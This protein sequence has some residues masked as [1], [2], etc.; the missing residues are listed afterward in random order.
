MLGQITNLQDRVKSLAQ[1]FG[2][3]PD[4]VGILQQVKEPLLLYGLYCRVGY[5][6]LRRNGHYSEVTFN[7][8]VVFY[9]N[10][11]FGTWALGHYKDFAFRQRGH[12]RE[13]LYYIFFIQLVA[14]SLSNL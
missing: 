9:T 6:K 1:Q 11:L 3:G 5:C 8:G 4:Q 14:F 2:I 13:R 7:S 12:Y 10:Y